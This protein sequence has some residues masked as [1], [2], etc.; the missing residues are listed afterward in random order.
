MKD[1]LLLLIHLLTTFAKILEPSGVKANVA[2][3]LLMKQQFLI[4]N[5]ARQNALYQ[6]GSA[7]FIA[8][9]PGK[10]LFGARLGF[11]F[12]AFLF[13][14]SSGLLVKALLACGLAALLSGTAFAA[15]GVDIRQEQNRF[16]QGPDTMAIKGSAGSGQ[17][18]DYRPDISAARHYKSVSASLDVG[19]AERSKEAGTEK[20]GPRITGAFD[21]ALE[22]HGIRFV[23]TCANEGS[24][25]RLRIVPTGLEIDN[26]PIVRTIDGI[27]TGA[28]VADLNMDGSPEIYVY[29]T[30][31]GSGSY[32]SLVAYSANR[33]KSLSDIYLPPVTQDKVASKGYMGHDEFAVGAGVLLH[34][35]PIYNSADTNARPTGGT[36]QLQYKLVPGEAGWLLKLDGMIEY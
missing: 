17:I 32:G 18:V 7:I 24:L 31:A 29:V 33:R 21:G 3:G 34:R 9:G 16:G 23:I 20:P 36:R 13:R 10:H 15:I 1:L 11:A 22:L 14:N 6:T 2:E 28:E 26:S 30:S 5:R 4:T 12:W 8:P 19:A 25:N 27:V 35:F